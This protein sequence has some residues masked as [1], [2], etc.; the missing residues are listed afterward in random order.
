MAICMKQS[1]WISH[2][3]TKVTRNPNMFVNFIGHY[4]DS[5]NPQGHGTKN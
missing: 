5:D 2:P 3:I 1:T 4:I